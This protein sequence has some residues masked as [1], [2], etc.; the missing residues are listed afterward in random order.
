MHKQQNKRVKLHPTT[1][2]ILRKF[3]PL[4]NAGQKVPVPG[5]SRRTVTRGSSQDLLYDTR[6]SRIT[7]D[8]VVDVGSRCIAAYELQ[9][10]R[11]AELDEVVA[12]PRSDF[13]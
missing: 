9:K 12:E 3:L 13:D 5:R 8:Q 1:L 10:I 6:D 4:V 2:S 7:F 11:P